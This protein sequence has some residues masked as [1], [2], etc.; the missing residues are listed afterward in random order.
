MEALVV[1]VGL[2]LLTW[3]IAKS[4]VPSWLPPIA[5]RV[6]A[7]LM[8]AASLVALLRCASDKALAAVGAAWFL[9]GGASFAIRRWLARSKEREAR[10]AALHAA[11]MHV[12]RRA[13]PPGP[14][15]GGTP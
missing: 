14:T 15:T 8:V 3:H 11:R 5:L 12:R 9:V 6:V 2:A 4:Y 13:P 10:R 1:G 7:V